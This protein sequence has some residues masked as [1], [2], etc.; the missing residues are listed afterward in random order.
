MEHCPCNNHQ[1]TADF[2]DESSHSHF[3]SHQGKKAS[4]F[5]DIYTHLNSLGLF[6]S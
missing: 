3:V 5:A 2:H 4:Y 6:D 1:P